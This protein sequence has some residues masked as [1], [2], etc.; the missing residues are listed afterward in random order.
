MG[1][2]GAATVAPGTPTDDS[3]P[4]TELLPVFAGLA[5]TVE[6]CR[7]IVERA[8]LE[9][10]RELANARERANA[11]VAQ[12]RIDIGDEQARAA[13]DVLRS[14]SVRD[15][16]VLDVAQSEAAHVTVAGE[17]QVAG[18]ARNVVERLIAEILLAD[19]VG[20]P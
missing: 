11:V 14:S 2:P 16:Q 7:T 13:A 8:T 1:A 4:A 3:S 17:T 6:E 15:T 9:A 5:G 19:P 12:A 20:Q 18:L 10:E